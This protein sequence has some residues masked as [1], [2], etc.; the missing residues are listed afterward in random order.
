[1]LMRKTQYAWMALGGLI[2]LFG[3]VLACKLR[4]GNKAI[5][6]PEKLDLPPLLSTND[7]K[8]LA[9]PPPSMLTKPV[10]P[11]RIAAAVLED[12]AG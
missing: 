9:S 1:M 7:E 4:D 8:Q 11:F 6:Q 3:L 12:G 2:C 10:G 5:A